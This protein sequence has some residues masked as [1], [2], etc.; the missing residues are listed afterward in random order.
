MNIATVQKRRFLSNIYK[1][2]YS[3]GNQ[4][5]ERLVRSA[6][7]EYFSTNT[8]GF[9]VRVDY[10]LLRSKAQTDVD[11]LNQIM[12][13]TLFNI[14]ILYE[15]ILD[16]NEELFSVVTSLNK[17]LESLKKKR[18]EL[19]SKI[20]DLLFIN[21]NSDGYF[22]SITDNFASAKNIDLNISDSIFFDPSYKNVTI[23]KLRSEQF[24]PLTLD[25]LRSINPQFSVAINGQTISQE[26]DSTN[27][28]NL[29]DG[30]TDTYWDYAIALAKPESVSLSITI[31]VSV[32]SL[33]SKIDGIVYTS[34]PLNVAMV[35]K[36]SDQ[37]KVDIV[38][39]Q[40]S[41][42]DYGTFS[43]S[44]PSDIYASIQL[45]LFKTEPDYIEENT[46]SP[47]VYKFGLRD[48]VIGSKYYA[49]SGFL[50]SSPLTIPVKQNSN[51]A[52]DAVSIDVVEQVVPGTSL[53]YY[54]AADNP[55]AES[56]SD[57]SWIPIS[58]NGS[59]S[60][61]YSS[62]V[63]LDGSFRRN[64]YIRNTPDSDDL[65]Y[66]PLVSSSNNFNEINPNT[67]IY[68]DKNIF[69]I[70]ALSSDL[71]Y[72][73][74]ILLGNIDCFKHNY[75]VFPGQSENNSRYKDLESW[76]TFLR[77]KPADML[78]S[79]LKEQ[80]G[81]IN[82]GINT[83][84][85][86]YI[87][88]KIMRESPASLVHTV[89]KSS[90]N[91]NLAIYLNGVLIADLP[92]GVT[93]KA[94]QW[95]FLAGVNNLVITYDKD[96]VGQMNFSLIEGLNISRYGS[97]FADYFTYLDP[98][99]FQNKVTEDNYYFTIDTVFGR[100]EIL[101]SKA[102]S[103]DSNFTFILKNPLTVD[104][105]RYRVDFTRYEDPYI[106]PLLESIRVKFK[107]RDI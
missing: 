11:L 53:N 55:S 28:N 65:G 41:K 107:H 20:D 27:F 44:I 23:S 73:N 31:P 7:N 60:S 61:G 19:E 6:F 8:P 30:L 80:L 46:N 48:L 13:N 1:L 18:L 98:L 17:K 34:S 51:L 26:V 71:S 16:N 68:S 102:I 25:N 45:T 64:V 105:I 50:V 91:F 54:I 70:A 97:V 84:A 75:F 79:V 43:F 59:E 12:A 40:N 5:D 62:I 87:Q 49:R 66:I 78:T 58:P 21:N 33:I 95:D 29:F 82:P 52:I 35:A 36:Y 37:Q 47:Y 38:R 56:V 9:P 93:S 94:I 100:K 22:Y 85:S 4:P 32:F 86:G 106:T 2:F 89:S 104:S 88:T 3:S 67:R 81:F 10:D 92:R 96:Y 90:S 77:D 103:G 57:F 101:A 72:I 83:Y 39:S 15:S 76:N 74:P 63:Y 69:R 42:G 99:E 14:D 24:T